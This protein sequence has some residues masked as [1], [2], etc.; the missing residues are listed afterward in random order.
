MNVTTI[1]YLTDVLGSVKALSG[2]LL[3][4]FGLSSLLAWVM[5]MV[6][7]DESDK[8]AHIAISRIAKIVTS[9]AI[10]FTLTFTLIPAKETMYL[11]AASEITQ[12]IAKSPEAKQI[13]DKVLKVINGKLDSL[14]PSE[15]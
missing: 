13:T 2:F 12:D 1:I 9:I 6:S 4:A 14:I 11:M 5:W 7:L 15:K 8:E 10:L 3:V